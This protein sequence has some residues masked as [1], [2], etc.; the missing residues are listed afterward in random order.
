MRRYFLLLPVLAALTA[1][2]TPEQTAMAG[3][4]TGAAIGAVAADDGDELKGAM[5][6]GAVGLAAGALIGQTRQPGMC[7]Y[8]DRY[9]REYTA[10]CP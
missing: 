3:A 1:C 2:Q 10:A 5:L 4:A 9:G 8:R 7:L 6:G